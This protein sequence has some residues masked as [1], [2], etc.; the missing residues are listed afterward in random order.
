MDAL[1]RAKD[2][3]PARVASK[4]LIHATPLNTCTLFIT[5][6]LGSKNILAPNAQAVKKSCVGE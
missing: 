2:L 4:S 1:K 5:S 6:F 3:S